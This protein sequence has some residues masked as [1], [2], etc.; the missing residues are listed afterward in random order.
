MGP[1]SFDSYCPVALTEWLIL[2]QLEVSIKSPRNRQGEKGDSNRRRAARSIL[3]RDEPADRE[4]PRAEVRNSPGD[5][6]KEN[7]SR[8]YVLRVLRT[9]RAD[10]R[11]CVQPLARTGRRENC[12]NGKGDRKNN[13]VKEAAR[14]S[15]RPLTLYSKHGKI[16]RSA[17]LFANKRKTPTSTRRAR[18]HRRRSRHALRVD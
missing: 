16:L 1:S 11:P 18:A 15:A 3:V 14:M 10:H 8:K 17:S 13:L 12:R 9:A 2:P 7:L 6:G 5:H 4:R